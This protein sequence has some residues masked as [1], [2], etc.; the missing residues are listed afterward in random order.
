MN[1]GLRLRKA[2]ESRL[3][4]LMRLWL[5]NRGHFKIGHSSIR[6]LLGDVASRDDRLEGFDFDNQLTDIELLVDTINRIEIGK[7]V[8]KTDLSG[9][10]YWT[11][12]IR[13]CPECAQVGYHCGYYSAKWMTKCPIHDLELTMKCPDCMDWWPS[14]S[15]LR[16]RKCKTCGVRQSTKLLKARGAF[17]SDNYSEKIFLLSEYFED[18]IFEIENNIAEY[19]LRWD[20]FNQ[21]SAHGHQS[22]AYP[23]FVSHFR[24]I[25]RT[26]QVKLRSYGV[27]I[28]GM[29]E[30]RFMMNPN[31]I[32]VHKFESAK[33]MIT[34][35]RRKILFRAESELLSAKRLKHKLRS[36]F[37]RFFDIDSGCASCSTYDIVVD[38]L[39]TDDFYRRDELFRYFVYGR[40][41]HV[42]K[43][44]GI[45]NLIGDGGLRCS[46]PKKVMKLLY[47]IELWTQVRV[48]YY[49]L[50]TVSSEHAAP[51]PMTCLEWA[52][53]YP[54]I[55]E[56]LNSY[57]FPFYFARK[58]SSVRLFIPKAFLTRKLEVD[59]EF[60]D[61]YFPKEAELVNEV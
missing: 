23:S 10:R 22:Q 35:A 47:E 53:R 42:I 60:L 40:Y 50:S 52:N 38:A 15:D 48:L 51:S 45:I 59:D 32:E 54:R 7:G 14:F 24:H 49:K 26:N 19:S 13:N 3:G 55:A 9:E 12:D 17:E 25:S 8:K 57:T 5:S 11:S 21:V 36:C 18:E 1:I 20:G 56:T 28:Y 2:G 41:R 6:Q 39:S 29:E 61:M 43:E 46:L 37:G 34:E 33:E 4:L 27:P 44:P 31:Q 30:Y 16:L 58:G